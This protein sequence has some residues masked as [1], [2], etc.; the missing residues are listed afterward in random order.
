VTSFLFFTKL[1]IST[2][3]E[4]LEASY[5]LLHNT[6]LFIF[7]LKAAFLDDVSLKCLFNFKSM[8][9]Q[10]EKIEIICMYSSVSN[11][12]SIKPEHSVYQV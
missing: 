3:T 9:P 2:H 4:G 10:M 5:L 6:S 1:L 7:N 11:G 8:K 12:N